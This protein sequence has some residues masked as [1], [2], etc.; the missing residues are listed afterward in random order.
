[1]KIIGFFLLAFIFLSSCRN[2]TDQTASDKDSTAISTEEAEEIT[3]PLY[4]V[5]FD[6]KTQALSLVRGD[7]AISGVGVS[8]VVRVMN[9]KY[10][11]IKLDFVNSVNDTVAV[12]ID[13][14]TKLTQ[15]MGSMGAEA[16]LAELTYSMTELDGI[17]AVKIDFEE[18]DHAMPGVYTR[19]DFGDLVKK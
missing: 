4:T 16:Y 6:E 17:K 10:N 2:I 5:E 11:G 9:K 12:K 15:G 3:A 14:A 13:D 18:G 7:E 19:S 8:D 1:M